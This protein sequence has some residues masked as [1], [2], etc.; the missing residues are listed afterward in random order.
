MDFQLEKNGWKTAA[1]KPVAN[2]DL[3]QQLD[4]LAAQFNIQWQWVQGH[5][6]NI[7]NEIADQLANLGIKNFQAA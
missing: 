5:N 6:G 7:N 2:A 3:W 1:K 4:A